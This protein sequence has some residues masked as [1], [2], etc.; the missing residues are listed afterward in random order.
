MK[1]MT[2][3][4]N[5]TWTPWRGEATYKNGFQTEAERDQFISRIKARSVQTWETEYLID[6]DS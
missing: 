1:T 5:V 6:I 4:Y 3:I 2:T